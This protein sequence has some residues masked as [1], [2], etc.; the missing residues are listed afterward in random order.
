[1]LFVNPVGGDIVGANDA[2]LA[3]YGYG[4]EQLLGM[5]ISDINS[6]PPG[7]IDAEMELA[8]SEK[9]NSFNFAH[10]LANGVIRQVEVH[11]GPMEVDGQTLLYSIVHDIT[12][13]KI[14]Q[15]QLAQLM[16]EQRA[17]LNSAIFGV[18]KLKDRR[19]VWMNDAYPA[20]LGY[21]REELI[22]QSTSLVYRSEAAHGEFAQ[23][24][25]PLMRSGAIFRTEIE[26]RR[27]DGS[28]GW[29]DISG[30]M[31]AGTDDESIWSFID[32]SE[33]RANRL[34][35]E[36]LIAEQRSILN[37]GVVGIV[38]VRERRVVWANPAFE[39]MLGYASGELNGT[40]T[41]RN[42]VSDEDYQSFGALAYG[43]LA[44][45][46]TV[47]LQ[48]RHLRKDRSEFWI[49]VSGAM[50]N[51]NNGESLWCFIDITEHKRLEEHVLQLAFHDPLTHLPNRR[52]LMD[53]L[54]QA[55]SASKR[56]GRF[57]ALLFIDLDNFKPLNDAHGH[58]VGDLLLV[59][60]AARLTHGV[61]EIDTVA[62]FG[63]DEFVL[64]LS[65]LED[66]DAA[67]RAQ[68]QAVAE[69]IRRSLAEPYRLEVG[70]GHQ[71]RA[72]VMH[73]CSASIGLTLFRD[74][75]GSAE[76]ILKWADDAMYLAKEEGRNRVHLHAAAPSSEV[77]AG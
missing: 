11:S 35:M 53:R 77:A 24:A 38:T 54:Q 19:F 44:L 9:R 18:V 55:I 40:E 33:K 29:Y 43:Q 42:F 32:I 1:M 50:L 73:S 17:I 10:R 51:A 63:G 57:A 65:D 21:K 72:A 16:A 4:R 46:G 67:S 22:G 41:R 59:E 75:Q 2:A 3:F 76:E 47:H 68:A 62:R 39:H 27:K 52:L 20:M 14:A 60:V 13:R 56:S 28:S 36:Q 74:H 45:G 61:R 6:L 5:R 26:Y 66:D 23:T 49:D 15:Q 7:E 31:L 12:D 25:Y 70:H 34:R 64:L 37:N 58:D 30:E 8:R 69:K 48:L 71:G